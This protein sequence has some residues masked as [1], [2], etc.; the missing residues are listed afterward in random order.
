M[1]NPS[2][3]IS[4]VSVPKITLAGKIKA[5]ALECRQ[6][7][8]TDGF[9]GVWRRYGWKIFAIFFFYYL[10]RDLLLYVLI[11]FLVAQHLLH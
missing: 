8:K 3:E 5:S 10:I 9:K 4:D 1:K 2:L 7:F 6:T 11:P